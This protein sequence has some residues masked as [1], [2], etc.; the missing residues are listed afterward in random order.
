MFDFIRD[1]YNKIMQNKNKKFVCFF[2]IYIVFDFYL[3]LYYEL[4]EIH[5]IEIL[6]YF[7]N[8]DE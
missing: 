6:L 2:E 7:M 4:N 3:F 1:I 5:V 8:F